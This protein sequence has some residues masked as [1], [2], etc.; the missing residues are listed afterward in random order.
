MIILIAKNHFILKLGK[1]LEVLWF[2]M[3]AEWLSQFVKG[4]WFF[5]T[6]LKTKKHNRKTL[7]SL[8]CYSLYTATGIH[9]CHLTVRKAQLNSLPLGTCKTIRL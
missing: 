1:N 5:A 4:L 2:S 3:L 8:C 6:P 9:A 7:C